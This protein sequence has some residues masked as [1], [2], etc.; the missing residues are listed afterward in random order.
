MQRKAVISSSIRAIGYE[1]KTSVLEVEFHSGPIYQYKGVP[2]FLF[3]GFVAAESKGNFF[4]SRIA[5][6]YPFLQIG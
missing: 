1:P 4:H 5:A 3:R 2:E 6:R